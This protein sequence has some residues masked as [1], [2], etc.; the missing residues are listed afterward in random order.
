MKEIGV[1]EAKIQSVMEWIEKAAALM[2][3]IKKSK[4]NWKNARGRCGRS[5]EMG[6]YASK[7]FK[8]IGAIPA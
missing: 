8:G 1:D 3:A 2:P 7:S 6:I 5:R 4:K